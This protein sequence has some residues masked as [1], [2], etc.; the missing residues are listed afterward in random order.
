MGDAT[1]DF[2][3]AMAHQ[4]IF[5]LVPYAPTLHNPYELV[6]LVR[7]EVWCFFQKDSL[8]GLQQMLPN[9]IGK[10]MK[11]PRRFPQ[12]L[13]QPCSDRRTRDLRFE[14]YPFGIL[15]LCHDPALREFDRVRIATLQKLRIEALIDSPK[16]VELASARSSLA[17]IPPWLDHRWSLSACS[18]HVQ[19]VA[20]PLPII[21]A[22][23]FERIAAHQAELTAAGVRRLGVFGSIARGEA[24]PESDVDI[25]VEFDTVPDLFEFDSLRERLAETLGRPVDLTTPQALEPR[26]RSQALDEVRYAA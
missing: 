3:S 14:I 5:V 20:A 25:L 4:V 23:L 7:K 22:E 12:A 9:W 10:A 17:S 19:S 21:E 26:L 8:K 6:A 24:V 2:V 11:Y 15:R 1:F 18:F 16:R 13:F